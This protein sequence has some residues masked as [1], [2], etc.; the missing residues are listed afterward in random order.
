MFTTE[1]GGVFQQAWNIYNE[2]QYRDA[3]AGAFVPTF[4][5]LYIMDTYLP[6][7]GMRIDLMQP[8]VAIEIDQ[9]I[10][11][12]FE[13]GNRSGRYVEVCF[14]VLGK[15][16]GERD[17]IASFIVDYFGDSVSIKSYAMASDSGTEV[18]KALIIPMNGDG[19]LII[20]ED[21]FTTR[22]SSIADDVEFGSSLLNWTRVRLAFICKI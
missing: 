18:E 4:P 2:T 8:F 13:E 6:A 5:F 20:K 19:D 11:R 1:T 15:N 3:L 7:M 9:Y 14:Q 21:M 17:D 10:K 12:P 16:R 22:Q